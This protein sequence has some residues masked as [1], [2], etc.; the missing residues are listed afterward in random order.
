MAVTVRTAAAEDVPALAAFGQQT[1]GGK[2]RCALRGDAHPDRVA[3]HHF[4]VGPEA[5]RFDVIVGEVSGTVHAY[6]VVEKANQQIRWLVGDATRKA[7]GTAI[8][9][10]TKRRYPKSWGRVENPDVREWASSLIPSMTVDGDRID[11]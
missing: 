1:M 2:W 4:I 7:A 8:M 9:D 10:E 5:D 6:A 3:L 11:L